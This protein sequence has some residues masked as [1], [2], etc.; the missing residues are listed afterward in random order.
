MAARGYRAVTA[1]LC[2]RVVEMGPVGRD[3]RY[4]RRRR[5]R[6]CFGQSVR[7]RCIFSA[8]LCGGPCASHDT[9]SSNRSERRWI[10]P[11][12]LASLRVLQPS[13]Y[14]HPGSNA[15]YMPFCLCC[16]LDE[17]YTGVLGSGA[18]KH[19]GRAGGQG[20]VR[21]SRRGY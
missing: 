12:V 1:F 16:L 3:H 8:S 9:S 6:P 21:L 18:R 10:G 14:G 19:G 2:T 4:R 20:L 7:Y 17:P 5:H 15:H 13:W 11:P